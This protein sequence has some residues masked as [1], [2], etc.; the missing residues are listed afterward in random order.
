MASNP[1]ADLLSAAVTDTE[2]KAPLTVVVTAATAAQHSAGDRAATASVLNSH[3]RKPQPT[4]TAK[5]SADDALELDMLDE[6]ATPEKNPPPDDEFDDEP[7]SLQIGSAAAN[8]AGTKDEF[9]D[10]FDE[11]VEPSAV[12]PPAPSAMGAPPP[13]SALSAA[14]FE[15]DRLALLAAAEQAKVKAE[16]QAQVLEAERVAKLAAER[17]EEKARQAAERQ[18]ALKKVYQAAT[19]EGPGAKAAAALAQPL[20]AKSKAEQADELAA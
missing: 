6:G 13:P 19:D 1:L 11:I 12:P 16:A 2:N 10:E 14:A 20:A 5:G 17:E 15:A 4:P 9:D 7:I 8:T 3:Y 18:A